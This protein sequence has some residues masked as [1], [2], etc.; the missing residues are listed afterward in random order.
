VRELYLVG[1]TDD[2]KA[3][4]LGESPDDDEGSFVLA[5]DDS[6][7][8][9]LDPRRVRSRALPR[10]EPPVPE[11]SGESG[12]TVRE[13]QDRLRHGATVREVAQEAGVPPQWVERFAP[14]VQAEQTKVIKDLHGA[15]FV[16]RRKG[17]SSEPLGAA[18]AANLAGRG[19]DVDVATDWSARQVDESLWSVR[20][21]YRSRG[22]SQ[23]AEWAFDLATGA[24]TAVDPLA[25]RLAHRAVD[26]PPPPPPPPP[27]RRPARRPRKK[28]AKATPT[29]TTKADVAKP[30][31]DLRPKAASPKAARPKAAPPKAAPPRATRPTAGSPTTAPQKENRPTTTASTAKRPSVKR[32]ATTAPPAKRPSA[33]PPP[34]TAPSAKRPSAK[35]PR[36]ESPPAASSSGRAAR[37]G[38]AAPDEARARRRGRPVRAGD[39]AS[40]GAARARSVPALAAPPGPSPVNT[41]TGS[42]ERDPGRQ[43]RSAPGRAAP[44]P[45]G[46]SGGGRLP[47]LRRLPTDPPRTPV[48]VKR[49]PRPPRA[50][51]EPAPPPEAAG[52]PPPPEPPPPAPAPAPVAA[53]SLA[54]G[55][56]STA[57][58]SRAGAG[59][60][61]GERVGRR[62]RRVRV[63]TVGRSG[64]PREE[65]GRG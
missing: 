51:E 46:E 62:L 39:A 9:A 36:A 52:R 42:I 28:A 17:P 30:A 7:R 60:N 19:V 57:G 45:A 4:I 63:R 5:L 23:V 38:P 48:L 18:V 65:N 40:T 58:G 31:P 2:R 33:K 47:P 24:V 3:M 1:T 55:P 29:R 6:V 50:V 22:R 64:G 34:T 25:A 10:F 20:C 61:G 54:A 11:D 8:D 49:P 26:A 21:S 43:R 41:P 13:M 44:P 12:L 56:G 14:P 27:R 37:P 59:Q 35:R 53:A 32:P 16:A 15:V